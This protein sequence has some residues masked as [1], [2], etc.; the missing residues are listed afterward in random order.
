[1]VLDRIWALQMDGRDNVATMIEAAVASVSVTVEDKKGRCLKEMITK[2]SIP[3]GHKIALNDIPTGHNLIK[4]GEIIG[5]AVMPI[6]AGEWVHVHNI[7]SL[8][9]RGG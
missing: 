9:G 7:E 8:R 4:Y 5:K 3:R 2:D 1:M 6:V